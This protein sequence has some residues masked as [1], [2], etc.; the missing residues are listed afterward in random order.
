VTYEYIDL[1][2][3]IAIAAEVTGLDDN[4]ILRVAKLSLADSALNAPAAGF[5]DTEFYPGFV[6]K[7]AVLVV[8]LAKN[9]PLPTATS[10]LLGS[11]C[12]SSSTATDG[13]GRR[14]PPSTRPSRRCSRS[15]PETGTKNRTAGGL[16]GHIVG[17]IADAPND[18][19]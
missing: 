5:G 4:T 8:R 3:Y 17:G 6:E 16:G 10:G 14:V 18:P 19:S 1:A 13:P 2:D 9:H 7:A 15:R 11:R 12:D